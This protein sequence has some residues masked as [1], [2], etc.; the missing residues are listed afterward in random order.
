M[1]W[2]V[3]DESVQPRR[4]FQPHV[5]RLEARLALS[6]VPVLFV[7]GQ[8]ASLPR[9]VI[10]DLNAGKFVQAGV[11]LNDFL[12]HLGTPPDNLATEFTVA[13]LGVVSPSNALLQA[14]R[15]VGYQDGVDLFA[16]VHDWRMPVAPTDGT[17]DG[18]LANVTADLMTNGRFDYGVSYLGYWLEKA[19]VAWHADP[20]NSGPFPGVDIV[21]H[22]EGNLLVRAY[23]SSAAYLDPSMPK[24]Q[25]W[26][27]AA[28]PFQGAS[29]IYNLLAN[30]FANPL[31]SDVFNGGLYPFVEL[32]Y[33]QVA[34][35]G[36]MIYGPDGA[37]LIT[38][39]SIS[40]PL[41]GKPDPYRFMEQYIPSIWAENATYAFLDGHTVN[42]NPRYRNALLLDVN[43]TA[44]GAVATGFVNQLDTFAV[45]YGTKN[46][47]LTYATT[48]PAAF[49]KPVL[50]LIASAQDVVGM[51]AYKP[52]VKDVSVA[53]NGDGFVA[54][55]SAVPPS[56]VGN[57][58]IHLLPQDYNVHGQPVDHSDTISDP[59]SIQ[60]ILGQLGYPSWL[61][62]TT[63]SRATAAHAAAAQQPKAA[64]ATL[65]TVFLSTTK[66][67]ANRPAV[68]DRYDLLIPFGLVSATPP[69]MKLAFHVPAL[70]GSVP[71][72]TV[73]LMARLFAAL[74]GQGSAA[75]LTSSTVKPR[76]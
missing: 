16:A 51:F 44:S 40:N 26:V 42:S 55:V 45:V 56:F 19:E 31:G 32:P 10:N 8:P 13:P 57:P 68:Q 49:I 14:L 1:A 47:T 39:A 3:R 52:W 60:A 66:P 75:S 58:A 28:P 4:A 22:S 23:V 73:T 20:T 62:T 48:Q 36:G 43:W 50:P 38:R 17:E 33:L 63:K 27:A 65:K 21:S 76:R 24:I 67:V 25:A 35:F 15:D 64:A 30:N 18:F 61:T 53:S 12:T 37:P 34:S 7:P 59:K 71:P 29:G 11:H 9:D 72:L 41:T 6:N 5:E 70:P 54:V 74:A 69:S 46:T 2:C